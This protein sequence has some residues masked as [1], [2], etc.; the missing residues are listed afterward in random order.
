MLLRLLTQSSWASLFV[1]L[2]GS[3]EF[4]PEE[5]PKEKYEPST[6]FPVI[7]LPSGY[8][9]EKVIG[10]LTYPTS[11]TWDDQQRMYVAEAGGAFFEEEPPARILRIEDGEAVEV[12]N[13]DEKGIGASVVGLVWHQGAFYFTHRAS[14]R[15]G[16]V[17]RMS[18]EGT[19]TELFSGVID[20]Q[21]D[22]QLNDIRVGPDGLMYVASGAGVTPP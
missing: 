2:L 17:S 5:R 6:Q 21:T 7:Q 15:T 16:A 18:P 19:V 10:G 9:I 8:R 11:I 14:D 22:H 1:L 12:A 3:C 13:L 4:T 20:S